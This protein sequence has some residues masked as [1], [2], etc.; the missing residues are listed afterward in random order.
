MDMATGRIV[1][2]EAL[3]RWKTTCAG[4]CAT[5][6]IVSSI[7]ENSGFIVAIGEWVLITRCL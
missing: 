5:R 2:Y 6:K 1:G 7:A 4:A 3:L